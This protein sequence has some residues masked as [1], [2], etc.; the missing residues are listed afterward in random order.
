MNRAMTSLS[1]FDRQL[2]LV[3]VEHPACKIRHLLEA[4]AAEHRGGGGAAN[5]SAADGDDLLVFVRRELFGPR[6]QIAKGYQNGAGNGPQ[7]TAVLVGF[8]DIEEHGRIS[9]NAVLVHLARGKLPHRIELRE[10]GKFDR[11]ILDRALIA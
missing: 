10:T 5:S 7:L 3:P 2:L 6:C 11:V 8:A 1:V 9:I 4:E